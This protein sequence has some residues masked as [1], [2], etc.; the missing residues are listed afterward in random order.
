M[1]MLEQMDMPPEQRAIF[2]Q[3]LQ[4]RTSPTGLIMSFVQS[5][6]MI[7]LVFLLGAGLTHLISKMFGGQGTFGNTAYLQSLFMVPINLIAAIPFIGGCI[8]FILYIYS[9]ALW[10]FSTKAE[11]KLTTGK[12]IGVAI[13]AGIAFLAIFACIG[14]VFGAAFAGMSGMAPQ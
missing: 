13:V 12:T 5:L 10:F 2:D 14:G 1:P 6:L 4:T 3:I 11:Q 7:P 9:I 8:G